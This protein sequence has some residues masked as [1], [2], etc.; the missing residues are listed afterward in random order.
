MNNPVTNSVN[1][2]LCQVSK[3]VKEVYISYCC[4][5]VSV[6]ACKVS[7]QRV[8]H[9]TIYQ[10]P[11]RRQRTFRDMNSLLFGGNLLL[12]YKRIIILLLCIVL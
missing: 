7:T 4:E 2:E 12:D 9:V 1:K 8:Q 3:M 10:G 5:F 6:F 11:L